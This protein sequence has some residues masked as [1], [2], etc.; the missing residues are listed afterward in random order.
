MVI[1]LIV[2]NRIEKEKLEVERLRHM[3]EEERREMLKKN[4]KEITN[5][6]EK[7]G[8]QLIVTV[9]NIGNQLKRC[10]NTGIC[11]HKCY[12]VPN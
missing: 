11:W 9:V 6:A 3:T 2:L 4:P 12:D 8:Y 5:Q 10:K 7:G 1:G